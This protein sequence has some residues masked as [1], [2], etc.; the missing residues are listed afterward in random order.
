MIKVFSLSCL[1][2]VLN[3]INL[4]HSQT[5]NFELPTRQRTAQSHIRAAASF[6]ELSTR[7]RTKWLR[8]FKQFKISGAAYA[9]ANNIERWNAAPKNF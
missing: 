5:S 1:R 7:Q 3:A 6:L 8:G 2:V 4:H 9:A